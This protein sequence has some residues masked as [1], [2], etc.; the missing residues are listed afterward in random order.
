MTFPKGSSVLE[1]GCGN[2]QLWLDNRDK[3]PDGVTFTLSDFSAG[4]LNEARNRMA[5]LPGNFTF[6]IIDAEQIPLEEKSIDILVANHMLYHVPDLDKALAEIRRVLRIGGTL[7][8]TTIGKRHLA[9]I[10]EALS[11]V[12]ERIEF[13]RIRH[14]KFTM[15]SGPSI[16]ARYL[17]EIEVR[18]YEDSLEVTN[19]EDLIK[20]VM[21]SV[22]ISNVG[23]YL[24]GK[25]LGTLREN[26]LEEIRRKGY[27]KVSK[28]SGMIIGRK[29]ALSA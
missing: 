16:L 23:S 10:G 27:I 11:R 8:C 12:D 25:G 13:N 21:S 5:G 19:A 9:E 6:S 20:Y 18:E 29:A 17:S 4:M 3:I 22:G 26:L 24:E 14:G 2:A 15:Q 28:E 1:L 7:Y